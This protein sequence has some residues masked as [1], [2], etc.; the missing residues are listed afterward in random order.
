MILCYLDSKNKEI[1]LWYVQFGK[2]KTPY[3]SP[4]AGCVKPFYE[5]VGNQSNLR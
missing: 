4:L 1:R 3:D 5:F 2:T